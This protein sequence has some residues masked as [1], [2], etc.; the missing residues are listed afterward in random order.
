MNMLFRVDFDVAKEMM[1]PGDVIAFSGEGPVSSVI[2]FFTGS[3]VSHVGI[4]YHKD[5]DNDDVLMIESTSL[6]DCSG[7]VFDRLK[8]RIK[9][10]NGDV[11]WLPLETNRRREFFNYTNFY[12][13]CL[14]A[15]GKLYDTKQAIYSAID[16]LSKFKN[17][18]DFEKYFCSELVISALEAA[19][20]LPSLNSSEYTPR[21]VCR[22]KAYL[23]AY[24]SL[25]GSGDAIKGYNTEDFDGC[26]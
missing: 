16:G 9:N 21:D 20:Y 7:V 3:R 17:K 1:L 19:G 13:H 15:N 6:D 11:W 4:V 14:V 18:E 2:K 23:G 10:Y 22:L 24:F 25:K 5:L 12:A 26:R 8:E